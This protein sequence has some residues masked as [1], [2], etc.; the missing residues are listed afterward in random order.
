M[1]V[2]NKSRTA[3]WILSV[4]ISLFLI[5]ASASGKLIAWEGKAEMFAKMGWSEDVMFKI[6]IVEVAIAILFL[7]PRT[8]FIACI[9]LAAYLGGATATHVR[10]GEAFFF[11][12]L[13][14]ILA[15]IALGLRQPGVFQLA[16]GNPNAL[17]NP[18]Q[19]SEPKV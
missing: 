10:A 18:N 19:H 13:I 7:V 8:A 16:L 11:P 4:L 12:I 1:R 15:W 2:S 5:F 14:A 17:D 6:G 9:L 3:G